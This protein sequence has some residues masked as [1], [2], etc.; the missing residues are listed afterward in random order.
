MAIGLASTLVRRMI[1]H[2][3]SAGYS[4][5]KAYSLR[6]TLGFKIRKTDFLR[7]WREINN[8]TRVKD[9]WKSVPIKYQRLDR[10]VVKTELDIG[11]KRQYIFNVD[12]FDKATD[13]VFTTK[14]S[15]TS[16]SILTRKEAE[17]LMFNI[18]KHTEDDSGSGVDV[19]PIGVYID[20][21]LERH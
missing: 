6:H 19:E 17:E 4:A 8:I 16:N 10:L 11:A 18:V 9:S 3:V 13:D 14:F 5:T 7:H 12:I 2:L 21:V 15:F 20:V 1:P